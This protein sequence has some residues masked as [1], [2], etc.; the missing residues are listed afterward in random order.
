MRK[1]KALNE[2]LAWAGTHRQY[3]KNIK[4]KK[5][6]KVDN[7]WIGVLIAFVIVLGAY[8]ISKGS[9]G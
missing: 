2:R 5:K 4:K 1:K 7:I 9:F 8:L 3:K 6:K